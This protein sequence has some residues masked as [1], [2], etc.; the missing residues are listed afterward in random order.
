M[1]KNKCSMCYGR[2]IVYVGD[3]HE[4]TIEPC[5]RCSK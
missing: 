2:G 3:R 4:Y 5:E 1:P